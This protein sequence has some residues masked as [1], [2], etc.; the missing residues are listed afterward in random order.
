MQHDGRIDRR[1]LP[2]VRF[3]RQRWVDAWPFLTAPI[4]LVIGPLLFF[5]LAV[6]AL[7]WAIGIGAYL[8][9]RVLS[10]RPLLDRV[11]LDPEFG[12]TADGRLHVLGR[13][14]E[15]LARTMAGTNFNRYRASFWA[16]VVKVGVVVI[17][18]SVLIGVAATIADRTLVVAAFAGFV[19]FTTVAEIAQVIWVRRAFKQ[20]HPGGEILYGPAVAPYFRAYCKT[21]GVDPSTVTPHVDEV[22]GVARRDPALGRDAAAAVEFSDERMLAGGR[23][24]AGGGL[25]RVTRWLG[26]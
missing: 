8:V 18:V 17:L 1:A 12:V 21:N 5:P 10:R 20:E 19:T 24:A 9:I 3:D 25:A 7:G 2:V 23:Q 15:L 6:V 16:Q 26:R 22:M 4:V 14:R 11:T 13:G